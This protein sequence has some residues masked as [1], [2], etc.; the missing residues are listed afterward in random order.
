MDE[1]KDREEFPG[2][3]RRGKELAQKANKRDEEEDWFPKAKEEAQE[4]VEGIRDREDYMIAGVRVNK[5]IGPGEPYYVTHSNF[6]LMDDTPAEKRLNHAGC[7]LALAWSQA[8]DIAE[9]VSYT[10]EKYTTFTASK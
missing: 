7:L 8:I 2:A 1:E 6:G 3:V 4:F 9:N 10:S 5:K